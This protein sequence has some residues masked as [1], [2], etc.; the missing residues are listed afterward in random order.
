MCVCGDFNENV[1]DWTRGGGLSL[2]AVFFAN[3]VNSQ[4]LR[5]VAISGAFYSWSK[6][7]S[8]PMLSALDRFLI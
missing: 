5:D 8:L 1:K 6:M 3:F 4:G 2:G 7:Q